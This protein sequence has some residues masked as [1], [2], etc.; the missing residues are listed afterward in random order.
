MLRYLVDLTRLVG[1]N[2]D[3]LMDRQASGRR[4]DQQISSGKTKIVNGGAIIF[5]VP[6]K[7]Q[8]NDTQR[9]HRCGLRPIL[10]S[11]YET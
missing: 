2:T 8:T 6:R 7:S 3:H 4:L 1:K 10:I 11:L 9:K 5:A